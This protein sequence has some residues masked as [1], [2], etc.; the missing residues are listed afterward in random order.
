MVDICIH[1]YAHT[2]IIFFIGDAIAYS[3]ASWTLILIG[4]CLAEA[5]GVLPHGRVGP[6]ATEGLHR[7]ELL[8]PH[9]R[10]AHFPQGFQLDP[11]P[12][13]PGPGDP[14]C[15][16]PSSAA[17]F[18]PTF[19]MSLMIGSFLLRSL[20]NLLQSAVDANMNVLR[21]WGGGVYEQ[22]LFYSICDELGIMVT[23]HVVGCV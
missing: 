21:V 12:L 19:L 3:H 10:P 15:V 13:L 11:G 9:Q 23:Q 7:A 4:C 18:F 14:G 22:E 5:T 2:H 8:L 1:V 20:K 16:S 6:G 17:A